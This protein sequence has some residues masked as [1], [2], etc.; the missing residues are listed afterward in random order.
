MVETRPGALRAEDAYR[1]MR[2][3]PSH[4]GYGAAAVVVTTTR[5]VD[6][7]SGGIG[8]RRIVAVMNRLPEAAGMRRRSGGRQRYRGEIPHEREQQQQSGSQAMHV[9][10]V[11]RNPK[12]GASIE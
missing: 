2:V 9:F 10:C 11:K 12:V 5:I 7:T 6:D 3:R 4:R 8:D 1:R